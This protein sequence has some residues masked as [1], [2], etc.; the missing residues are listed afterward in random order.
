[1]TDAQLLVLVGTLWIVPHVP[2]RFGLTSGHLI[3]IAACLKGL[4]W[5]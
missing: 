3:L 2:A 1:M 4:G 5:I